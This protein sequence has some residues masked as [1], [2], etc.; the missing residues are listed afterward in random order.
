MEEAVHSGA[1]CEAQPPER[2]KECLELAPTGECF[3]KAE[4]ASFCLIGHKV[5]S[6]CQATKPYCCQA[7][8][9]Q[10]AQRI[11]LDLSHWW[12]DGLFGELSHECPTS[13]AEDPRKHHTPELSL[14]E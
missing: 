3:R 10:G 1:Q 7:D 14:G 4:K 11:A 12:G 9:W 2:R 6:A 8:S 5:S 13:L